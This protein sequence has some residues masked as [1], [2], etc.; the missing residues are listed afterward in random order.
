MSCFRLLAGAAAVVLSVSL[1][2][3]SRAW[4]QRSTGTL[5]GVVVDQ[6]DAPVGDVAIVIVGNDT[7]LKRE[8]ATNAEGAFSFPMLPPGRYTLRATRSGFTPF[9]VPAVVDTN[10]PLI[11]RVQLKVEGISEAVVVSAQKRGDERIQDV[12][13]AVTA[14][15][16]GGLAD[17]GQVLLRDYITRVPGLTVQP[18]QRGSQTLTVRGV[19]SSTA[20]GVMVDDVP[21]GGSTNRVGGARVPEFDPGDLERVE[22]LRGPQGTLYGANSLGGLLKFVTKS[23]SFDSYRLRL[24]AGLGSV[25]GSGSPGYNFRGSANIPVSP[26]LSLR[27]SGF[28]RQDP[29]YIDNPVLGLQAVNDTQTYGARVASFWV[30]SPRWSLR[31]SGLY[32]HNGA[33]HQSLAYELP[34]LAPLE[35]NDI[36]GVGWNDTSRHAYSAVLRFDF[37]RVNL[38][39]VTAHGRFRHDEVVDY[40][41]TLGARSLTYFGVP[42]AAIQS[43]FVNDKFT[44]EVRLAGG[45]GPRLDWVA[46]GFF[47]DE[48]GPFHQKMFAVDPVSGGFVAQW[49]DG[50]YPVSFREYSAFSNL[51]VRLTERFDLQ[52][53]G[54]RTHAREHQGTATQV[55]LYTSVV[56]GEPSPVITPP[57]GAEGDATTYLVTPRFRIT[58]NAMAYARLAS[59][60]RPGGANNALGAPPSYNPDRTQSYEF[61]IKTDAWRKIASIDASL[62][63]T[64][65]KDIH[66]QLT[67]ANRF[68]YWS[69]AGAA[70]SVGMELAVDSRPTDGLSANGWI[71]YNHAV[72]TE[73]FPAGSP[74]VGVRGDRLPNT[75]RVSGHVSVEQRFPLLRGLT[76]FAGAAASYMGD[77]LGPFTATPLRNLYPRYTKTDLRVGMS[78]AD[79]TATLYIN[80]L[81]NERGVLSESGYAFSR[82]YIVPRSIGLIVARSFERAVR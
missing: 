1:A 24:E 80:N 75:A 70:K 57:V 60:Y 9:E 47:T 71:S 32:Q 22:V 49:W 21:F 37:G 12:P 14:I 65:W 74:N 44:Q 78:A 43:H 45:L 50:D 33:D 31:L 40:T 73:G 67:T 18:G 2:A 52:V 29:G 77:R 41:P 36:A 69:N 42:G 25:Q 63:Y 38:M 61:G 6:A 10:D 53:G 58:P 79:W 4:S 51:T 15:D 3:P 39:S 20:I 81:T 76:G 72:L 26:S 16:A 59:G 7:A 56:L 11:L 68:F 34:G 48:N 8:A 54:R 27:V 35:Q 30:P 64:D 23:P 19:G 13:M 5:S 66:T 82:S 46:G 17:S 28:R 62:F 55:G